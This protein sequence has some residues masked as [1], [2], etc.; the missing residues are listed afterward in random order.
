[1]RL[2][3]QHVCRPEGGLK[4]KNRRTGDPGYEGRIQR[5]LQGV[6]E[7]KYKSFGAAAVEENVS[8]SLSPGILS[9][10]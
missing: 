1:M 6:R 9:T 5:A 7:G 10:N 4:R 2:E 8:H 3:I